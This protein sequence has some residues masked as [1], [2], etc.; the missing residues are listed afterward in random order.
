MARRGKR[1]DPQEVSV[2]IA[3]C[4]TEGYTKRGRGKRGDSH[5]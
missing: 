4:E 2:V 3:I 5:L 1:G